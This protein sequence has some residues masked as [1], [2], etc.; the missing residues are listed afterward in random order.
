MRRKLTL[1]LVLLGL[2]LAAVGFELGGAWPYCLGARLGWAG[3][4]LSAVGAYLQYR[5][6]GSFVH[7]FTEAS[8]EPRIGYPEDGAEGI[9]MG[10]SLKIPASH[11]GKGR[12]ASV[13]VYQAEGLKVET[14]VEVN[15]ES[16]VMYLGAMAPFV[17]RV[18]I[19]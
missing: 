16:G 18:V 10:F 4:V 14:D 15:T 2:V 9:P 13:E 6:T 19:K 5:E 12:G 17:G 3:V 11:H 7:Q 1:A 8:W